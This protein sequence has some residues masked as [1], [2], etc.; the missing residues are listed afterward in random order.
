[1]Y[2]SFRAYVYASCKGILAWQGISVIVSGSKLTN[3]RHIACVVSFL[4]EIAT[5]YGVLSLVQVYGYLE[6]NLDK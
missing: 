2:S 3:Y 4:L 6:R 1:M 5:V